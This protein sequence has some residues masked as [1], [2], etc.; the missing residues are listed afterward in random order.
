MARV[1]YIDLQTWP[2]LKNV[3]IQ[4]LDTNHD[5]NELDFQS[6]TPQFIIYL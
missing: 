6:G 2:N 3:S 1:R 4:N 5:F